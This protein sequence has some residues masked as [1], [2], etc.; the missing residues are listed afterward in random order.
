MIFVL[1]GR[2]RLIPTLP[3]EAP[4]NAVIQW[5]GVT[6]DD[7]L[8]TVLPNRKSFPAGMILN[9]QEL[10]TESQWTPL[11]ECEDEGMEVFCRIREI[12][13]YDDDTNLDDNSSYDDNYDQ[14]IKTSLVAIT[15]AVSISLTIVAGG[16]LYFSFHQSAL[17][18][19]DKTD[20]DD[21][22][23]DTITC[24]EG[25]YTGEDELEA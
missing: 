4:W 23:Q 13:S 21:D 9:H 25:N 15:I 18:K 12:E 11:Q 8:D 14:D 1:I 22:S 17:N 24:T 5:L 16:M 20:D 2:G 10:F 7:E 6:S 3:F 19:K